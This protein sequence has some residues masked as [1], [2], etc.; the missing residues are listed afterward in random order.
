MELF[1]KLVAILMMM[2]TMV[3]IDV[4]FA[5]PLNSYSSYTPCEKCTALKKDLVTGC[6][7][8]ITVALIQFEVKKLHCSKLYCDSPTDEETF[9]ER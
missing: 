1:P 4:I 2:M 3:S 8:D 6:N 9:V 7:G 5:T